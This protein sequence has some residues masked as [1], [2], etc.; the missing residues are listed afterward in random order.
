MTDPH[1]R[2]AQLEAALNEI[3]GH[4]GNSGRG[5]FG[6]DER[7]VERCEDTARAALAS[8]PAPD[9]TAGASMWGSHPPKVAALLGEVDY[10]LD[11]MDISYPDY[12]ID[13]EDDFLDAANSAW[14]RDTLTRLAAALRALAGETE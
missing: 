3:L 1:A 10:I 7:I 2:I 13:P 11:G 4:C 12:E 8:A 5:A 14:A 9:T 6:V